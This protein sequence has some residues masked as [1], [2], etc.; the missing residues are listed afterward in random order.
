MKTTPDND[1]SPQ[2]GRLP[3]Q[4]SGA[5]YWRNDRDVEHGTRLDRTAGVPQRK[6]SKGVC[7]AALSDS[8]LY[9]LAG[10]AAITELVQRPQ[11]RNGESTDFTSRNDDVE[12]TCS[13]ASQVASHAHSQ[14]VY[15][16]WLGSTGQPEQ[17]P[18]D[19][20][21]SIPTGFET[22]DERTLITPVF[23]FGGEMKKIKYTIREV[24]RRRDRVPARWLTMSF[25]VSHIHALPNDLD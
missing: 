18:A 10:L 23:R 9:H 25:S 13:L 1:V 14:A 15:N 12:L 8:D 4:D 21:Q 7:R 5:V 11:C 2:H 16:A 24:S 22:P 17:L 3:K 20:E 19:E 6:L